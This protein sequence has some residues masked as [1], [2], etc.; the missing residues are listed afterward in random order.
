[1]RVTIKGFNFEKFK[2]NSTAMV[3]AGSK[4]LMNRSVS[5]ILID[6]GGWSIWSSGPTVAEVM[7]YD[8]ATGEVTS[9][10]RAALERLRRPR[11]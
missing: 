11:A 5:Q 3:S 7:I 10:W 6:N 1:M 8:F 9:L 2:D 4:L